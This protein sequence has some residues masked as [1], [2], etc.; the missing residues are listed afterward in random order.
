MRFFK[1]GRFFF[2]MEKSD[3]RN[4]LYYLTVSD[5]YHPGEE[6][7]KL[8]LSLSEAYEQIAEFAEIAEEDYK[9]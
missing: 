5:L 2:K 3:E 8:L 4:D 6:N 7:D 9:G 1:V